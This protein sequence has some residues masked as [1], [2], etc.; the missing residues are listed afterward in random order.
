VAYLVMRE[1]MINRLFQQNS[2]YWRNGLEGLEALTSAD[3]GAALVDY[4][5]MDEERI[6]GAVERMMADGRHALAAET[7]RSAQA[8]LPNSPRLEALRREVNLKLMEQY[9]A[10]NPFKFI[11]YA[12]E[13]GQTLTPV[14]A[15]DQ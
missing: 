6:A 1:N 9:Q 2:G 10:F 7:L 5:G 3:H 13:A 4:L 8:R 11:V 15:G 12:A 14:P